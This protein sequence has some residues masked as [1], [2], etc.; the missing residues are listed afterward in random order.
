[1][2]GSVSKPAVARKLVKLSELQAGETA[3]VVRVGL[4]DQGCRRRFAE[5]GIYEGTTLTVTGAG[6]TLMVAIGNGRMGL[7]AQCAAMVT[8]LRIR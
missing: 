8:V 5:M 6:D 3:R 1:M 2:M 7:S 4:L